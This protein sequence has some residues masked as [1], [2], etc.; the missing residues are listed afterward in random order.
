MLIASQTKSVFKASN[1]VLPGKISEAIAAEWVIPEHPIVSTNASSIIPSLTLRVNLHAP[2]WGAHQP[3]PWVKP[4]ISFTSLACTH[5]PSSG[6]GAA[7]WFGPLAITHI[8]ST[9]LEYIILFSPP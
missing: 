4:E 8:S 3:I 6:I 5:L 2:C 7:P 1:I 9:S